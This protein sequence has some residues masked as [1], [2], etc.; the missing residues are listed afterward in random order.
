MI[1]IRRLSIKTLLTAL[2]SILLIVTSFPASV[3]AEATISTNKDV[4]DENEPIIVTADGG[5]WV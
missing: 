3:K 5:E 1:N 4:Y 2:I